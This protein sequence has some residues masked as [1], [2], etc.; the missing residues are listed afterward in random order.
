MK[1][2][3]LFLSGGSQVGQFIVAA[4]E[5]RRDGVRLAATTS[6]SDDPGLWKFDGL[7]LVPVT[8][9]QTDVF[10]A[11]LL[12][13]L[14]REP[15]GLIVPCRDDDVVALA[16][17]VEANPALAPMALC[18]SAHVARTMSDKWA[19]W[20]LCQTHGLPHA[21]SFIAGCGIAAEQF[22]SACGYPLVAKPRDGFSS[23]G[24]YL[25]DNDEQL[26]RA[27][28]R[29]NYVLQEY[30][31][32]PETYWSLKRSIETEGLPLLH[33]LRGLKLGIQVMIAPTGAVSRIFSTSTTH[34]HGS[35][36]TLQNDDHE[37]L[38]LGQRCGEVFS[39]LGW[40]GPLNVQC[41]RDRTG[42]VTIHEFSGRFA[43]STVGR[44]MLGYDQLSHALE[45]FTGIR[46]PTSRWQM[47]P[48]TH[49]VA[50]LASQA[51]DP[52]DVEWLQT[53]H[54]WSPGGRR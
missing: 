32:Q 13:I 31:G 25:V 7:Y 42:R 17:L 19:S 23:R 45:L 26:R 20:L 49:V 11:R 40:R 54:E 29:P 24:I 47:R 5:G 41:Q 8:A 9:G 36:T 38:Q 50:Q 35:M 15:V 3:L 44:A 14:A 12:E 1:P 48:A 51:S 30:L 2:T 43:G 46:L 33:T 28:Q 10:K 16:E 37:A 53:H 18:G 21:R 39:G 6:V 34:R 22:A 4:L 27:L 52:A